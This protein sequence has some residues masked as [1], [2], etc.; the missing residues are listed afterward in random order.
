MELRPSWRDGRKRLYVD[1]DPHR[2]LYVDIRGDAQPCNF[3]HAHG[4]CLDARGTACKLA[5]LPHGG[6]EN[7]IIILHGL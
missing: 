3:R 7:I 6:P 2:D 5:Q 1:T 4:R